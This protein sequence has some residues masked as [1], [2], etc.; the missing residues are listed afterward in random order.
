MANVKGPDIFR[1]SPCPGPCCDCAAFSDKFDR[2][3]N[4]DIGDDWTN[5][6]G[7]NPVDG[8]EIYY[9]ALTVDSQHAL[10][11]CKHTVG[12][13]PV[14]EVLMGRGT[15]LAGVGK[16]ELRVLFNSLDADNYSYVA[17]KWP[18]LGIQN[19][20]GELI[21]N[22]R[23]GGTDNDP[24]DETDTLAPFSANDYMRLRIC[25]DDSGDG[26]ADVTVSSNHGSHFDYTVA[27]QY[28]KVGLATGPDNH[29]LPEFDEFRLWDNAISDP[30]TKCPPCTESVNP[31]QGPCP[32]CSG[33][34]PVA[35]LVTIADSGA[36]L[37]G[38][39]VV[40]RR[41]VFLGFAYAGSLNHWYCNWEY[42]L[43]DPY[44]L[45]LEVLRIMTPS[46]ADYYLRVYVINTTQVFDALYGFHNQIEVLW[47]LHH[48]TEVP[49]CMLFYDI[50]V[51]LMRTDAPYMDPGRFPYFWPWIFDTYEPNAA[52]CTVRVV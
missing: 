3:N 35:F 13:S 46:R 36:G 49:E 40:E 7:T 8:F 26:D 38:D 42:D 25:V 33:G 27:M 41:E 44:K 23:T 22:T 1:F 32:N 28:E 51:P 20:T 50:D 29:G 15:L 52:T 4:L 45:R 43:G 39:Y 17:V 11:I 24:P 31:P 14:I 2:P 34:T 48:G 6:P 16:D 37:D 19:P 21:R 30:D 9:N 10:A 5:I 18:E 47:H 12:L